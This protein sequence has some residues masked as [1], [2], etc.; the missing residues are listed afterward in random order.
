LLAVP[1]YTVPELEGSTLSVLI[2]SKPNT[3][4]PVFALLELAPPSILFR[5]P[6]PQVPA[7]T[8]DRLEGSVAMENIC[9]FV[10]PELEGCHVIPRSVLLNTPTPCVEG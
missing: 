2:I 3:V 1:A 5:T 8:V 7:Y 6:A 4:I 9:E 10:I